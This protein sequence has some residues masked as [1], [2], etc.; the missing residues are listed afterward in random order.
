MHTILPLVNPIIGISKMK[1]EVGNFVGSTGVGRQVCSRLAW[2]GARWVDRAV[3]S[4][5]VGS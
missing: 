1:M 2:Y 3:G 5:V 4:R